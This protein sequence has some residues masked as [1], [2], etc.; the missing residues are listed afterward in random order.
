V[1]MDMS[2]GGFRPSINVARLESSPLAPVLRE[3]QR[4]RATGEAVLDLTG[5]GSAE[6][7]SRADLETLTA[8]LKRPD[9]AD[10]AVEGTLALRAAVARHLSL[11]SGG[12]PVNADHV[13]VAGSAHQGI[14][15]ACFAL[16]GPGERVLVPTPSWWGVGAAVR[17]ARAMPDAVP[18]DEEWSLKVGR[19]ELDRAADLRTRGLVLS[20][21]VEA[22]GAVYTAAELATI[23]EWARE[24]D[25]R[26]LADESA[27]MVH[28]GS[29]PAPS[30]LD[31][32]DDLLHDTVVVWTTGAVEAGLGVATVVASTDLA[33]IIGRLQAV[34][35][36][37]APPALQAVAA[38]LL[39][40]ER[41]E[42]QEAR[43][44]A[45]ARKRRDLVVQRFRRHLPGVEFVEPL[46][47][48]GLFF[49]VDGFF[50]DEVWSGVTF[51]EH[52]AFEGYELPVHGDHTR[53]PCEEKGWDDVLLGLLAAA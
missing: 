48:Y 28:F 49:R 43:R 25:V 16:F 2:G 33:R 24:R 30:V 19:G 47:G 26:V 36:G 21:P 20:S 40:D 17:L 42:E 4:R 11:R 32:P 5:L 6:P 46:G 1:T 52:S 35:A 9:G 23:L 31:L 15:A 34:A 38:E 3:V 53:G 50:G 29:G 45:L 44:V 37:G 14:F 39:A 27:R 18:G 7:P 8:A 51:C 41:F 10:V 22:T 13:V 12:R